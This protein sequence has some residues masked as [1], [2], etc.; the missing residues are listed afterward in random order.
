MSTCSDWIEAR[1]PA[2]PADLEQEVLR[3][4]ED[5]ARGLPLPA[6]LAEAGVQALRDA[7]EIGDE[8]SAA[9]RLLAA[10]ALLTYAIEAAAEQGLDSVDAVVETWSP[11]MLSRALDGELT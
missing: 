1:T 8:R 5:V 3:D 9:W 11:A 2:P 7:I 10:D 6:A 4:V